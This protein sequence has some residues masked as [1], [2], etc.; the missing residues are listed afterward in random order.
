MN[1]IY[2]SCTSDNIAS[3]KIIEKLGVKLIEEIKHPI[4]YIFYYDNIPLRRIYEL[5]IY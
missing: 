3:Y 4:D 5:R 1:K 2:L